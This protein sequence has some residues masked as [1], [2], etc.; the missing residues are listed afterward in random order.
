MK[1]DSPI[2][3]HIKVDNSQFIYKG[4]PILKYT[5]SASRVLIGQTPLDR[6]PDFIKSACTKL[7]K[8]EKNF[9]RARNSNQ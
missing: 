2:M 6:L 3:N 4:K 1:S 9:F 8:S 5:L 7:K